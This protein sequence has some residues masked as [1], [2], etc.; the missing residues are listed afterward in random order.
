[1]PNDAALYFADSVKQRKSPEE[2]GMYHAVEIDAAAASYKRS[3]ESSYQQ[4]RDLTGV[5]DPAALHTPPISAG[6]LD[7]PGVDD[8]ET[9]EA[10]DEVT[11][12]V[13]ETEPERKPDSTWLKADIENWLIGADIE[14][15]SGA[16]K[17]EL[18]ALVP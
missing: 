16:T 2:T 13:D 10:P 9:T 11:I 17:T 4:Y 6:K 3:A 5:P 1:M 7:I 8:G 15:P 14:Y 18:L 12:V